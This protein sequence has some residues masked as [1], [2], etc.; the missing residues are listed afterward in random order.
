MIWETRWYFKSVPS[1]VLGLPSLLSSL[2]CRK[3][4]WYIYHCSIYCIHYYYHYNLYSFFLN[5]ATGQPPL[6]WTP[7]GQNSPAH[8]LS[9]VQWEW[10][11]ML[12]RDPLEQTYCPTHTLPPSIMQIWSTDTI[13]QSALLYSGVKTQQQNLLLITPDTSMKNMQN[14]RNGT[15]ASGVWRCNRSR[16][17]GVFLRR[18]DNLLAL[19]S[20]SAHCGS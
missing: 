1:L 10:L 12:L 20:T 15:P 2:Y 9:I 18:F 5:G 19:P 17:M 4:R 6:C 16:I 7:P 8:Y 11:I 3:E 14:N 13:R